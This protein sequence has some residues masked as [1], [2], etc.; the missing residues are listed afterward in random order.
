MPTSP[1]LT[2]CR[3][4]SVQALCCVARRGAKPSTHLRARTHLHK[5]VHHT[6]VRMF[7]CVHV[8]TQV[9]T[10]HISSSTDTASQLRV[11]E[12]HTSPCPDGHMCALGETG[13]E[14]L[15]K[16]LGKW[17][18]ETATELN[19]RARAIDSQI[20]KVTS[21]ET[22]RSQVF[23]LQAQKSSK[24]R[25]GKPEPTAVTKD[26][27]PWRSPVSG[28]HGLKGHTWRTDEHSAETLP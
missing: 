16:L 28:D 4:L 8:L 17:N 12:S 13:P 25:W 15:G 1:H 14:R 9:P 2:W 5:C 18:R 3:L 7:I 19:T 26:P 21:L 23:P 24:T 10:H 6:Q 11:L 22:S 20:Q 27:L